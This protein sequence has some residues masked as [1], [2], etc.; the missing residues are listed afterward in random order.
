M[1][2]LSIITPVFNGIRFI[3]SC[4][5]NVIEQKCPNAEH[6]IVDGGSSD[7]TVE[8]IK[9]Y[10]Q[11]YPHLRWVSEK[12]EGQSD[13][14]N[15]GIA[16]ANGT[17]LS[18]LNVDDYY[19]PGVLNWLLA[20]FASFSEPSL[21]VGNCNMWDGE[22]KLIGLNKPA[23][24]KLEQLLVGNE[25]IY[26]FP[27][28]PSAYFYH[29]SLHTLIGMYDVGEHYAMDIEFLLRAVSKCQVIYV[30]KILGN[31]RFIEGAKTFD[32]MKAGAG[33]ARFRKLIQQY[34]ERLTFWQKVHLWRAFLVSVAIT[35]LR[36]I[37]LLCSG[38]GI[39]CETAPPN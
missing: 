37:W 10:A 31:F 15:K 24:L 18:F 3:E 19:E 29:R 9:R 27:I 30:D 38:Q 21:L 39:R 34:R 22:E 36:K 6:L 13:A 17:I 14:M 12:D 1:P 26:P 33:E 16:M 28:N 8:V 11:E 20:Q 5:L 35:L 25:S 2:E 32:D 7:G 23:H 4:I